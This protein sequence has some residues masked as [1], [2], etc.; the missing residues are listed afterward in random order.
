MP[1]AAVPPGIAG[2]LRIVAFRRLWVSLTLSGLGDWVGLLALTAYANAA[3]GGSSGERSLAIAGVLLL[4]V[5]PAMLVG[6]FAGYVADRL[7]RRTT[8]V[9]GNVARG[10]IFA[11]IPLVDTLAWVYVATVLVEVASM[12]WLPTK[13]ATVPALVPI[14][15]LEDANRL[16]L[17]SSYGSAVPAAGV[18]VGL[19]QLTDFTS[20]HLGWGFGGP[21]DLALWVNAASLVVAGLLCIR[22]G[23]VPPAG[24]EAGGSVLGDIAAG[25]AYVWRT[26]LVRALVGG[27]VAAFAAGGVVIGLGRVFVSDLDA[28]DAG[29]GLLFGAVFAGLGGGMWLGPR[30][31]RS[32]PRPRVFGIALVAAGA[33]LAVIAL[34]PSIVA[35]MMLVLALGFAGGVAWITGYTLLGVEVDESVRGRTFALVQSLVRLALALVLALAPLTAGL[36]GSRR[37]PVPGVGAL[38]YSGPQLTLLL[39]GLLAVVAGAATARQTAAAASHGAVRPPTEH[40]GLGRGGLAGRELG[41]THGG[42]RGGGAGDRGAP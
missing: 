9:V 20:Q 37:L 26:P 11:T 22:V 36:I 19:S 12:L 23:P 3:A 40:D 24:V 28:S 14:E 6:P 30:V 18:F 17:A 32:A 16:N 29:Y 21:V 38:S 15:C 41:D 1:D 39:A 4:R 5:L 35:V 31:L 25:W 8:L 10:L 33:L 13:D 34:V 42:G 7:D 2:V 27:I